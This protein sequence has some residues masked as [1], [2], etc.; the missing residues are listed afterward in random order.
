MEDMVVTHQA[1]DLIERR[2]EVLADDQWVEQPFAALKRDQIFRLFEPNGETVL[3]SDG[4]SVWKC[5]E[6]A[7][8]DDRGIWSV[9]TDK[10]TTI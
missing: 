5:C 9:H 4:V 10:V 6:D 7:F 1:A 3:D 2:V 8:Q